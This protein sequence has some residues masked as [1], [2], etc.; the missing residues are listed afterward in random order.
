M[1]VWVVEEETEKMDVAKE[2]LEEAVRGLWADRWC[3][4]H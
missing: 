3:G 1:D 2:G 4:A